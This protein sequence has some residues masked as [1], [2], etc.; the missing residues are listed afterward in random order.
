MAMTQPQF[1]LQLIALF[2]M[3]ALAPPLWAQSDTKPNRTDLSRLSFDDLTACYK[4][5]KAC[6]AKDVWEIS[7]EFA[8]RL[9][10]LPSD[11]LIACFEDWKLCGIAEDRTTGWPI[12]DELARRGHVH[13]M[14]TIYWKDHRWAIRNGIEHVA[15]HFDTPE[16]TAFMRRVV[17]E[18]ANDGEERYWPVNY[19]AKKC[20]PT[21]LKELSTGR[22]R[23]QG[24]LQYQTSVEL[25]GKCKYRP[26]VP[27][28]VDSALHDASL[29]I[30]DAADNSLHALF[31]DSPREFESLEKEQTY[32][33]GRAHRDGFKV[34]CTRIA[35]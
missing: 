17:A 10:S 27:Y 32:F 7:D 30:V 28:L 26:A 22:Y 31:P 21:G 33:C 19:L 4:N 8:S 14:L 29:N 35:R 5:L 20:D 9:P 11:R 23:N 2:A 25:F 12:S 13:E 6:G 1:R 16:V 3:L 15:Y 24:S 18:K 34:T